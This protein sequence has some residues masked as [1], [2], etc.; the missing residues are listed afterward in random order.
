MSVKLLDIHA[1]LVNEFV[2]KM[3]VDADNELNQ[4]VFVGE[5]NSV[6]ERADAYSQKL[7]IAILNER[8][9]QD[10]TGA[11]DALDALKPVVYEDDRLVCECLAVRVDASSTYVVDVDG[12]GIN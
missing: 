1:G 12:D 7:G 8:I 4:A 10:P 5:G 2:A 3:Q 6:S 9:L 11:R